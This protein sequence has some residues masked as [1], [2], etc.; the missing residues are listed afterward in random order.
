MN[1]TQ[2]ELER[3]RSI[4]ATREIGQM[5]ETLQQRVI[6]VADGEAV[7]EG[8]PGP[9]FNNYQGRIHG[10]YLA[11]LIDTAMG[12]SVATKIQPKTGFGTVDLSVKF[13]RKFVV[14][15][16]P[17]FATAR[18]LHA[19]RT[20]ITTECKVAD[21]AGLLYAHGQGTFLVYPK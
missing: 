20:M 6:S 2:T 21:K 13:V 19:G 15:T 12:W 14:A 10:G 17:V 9:Q 1:E 7:V 3:L 18:V 8:T 16:G 11:A 4:V 5:M